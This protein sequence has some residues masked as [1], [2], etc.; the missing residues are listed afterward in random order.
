MQ[1]NRSCFLYPNRNRT[2][3]CFRVGLGSAFTHWV[4]GFQGF[5][6][7]PKVMEGVEVTEARFTKFRLRELG[8]FL[9]TRF[10]EAGFGTGT[11]DQGL[12][13]WLFGIWGKGCCQV[14]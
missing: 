6:K 4:P 3:Y 9:G 14:L 12:G 8:F 2:C 5:P 7:V 11:L 10:Q 13:V 1:G